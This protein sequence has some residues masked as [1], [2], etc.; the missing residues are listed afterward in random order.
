MKKVFLL[1]LI[2]V[3]FTIL[4]CS[5][6]SQKAVSKSAPTVVQAS[7]APAITSPAVE[8]AAALPVPSVGRMNQQAWHSENV[9]D[10]L[11]TA[12]ALRRTSL[13]GKFD[14]VI[15]QEG[16]NS[17]LS[18]VRHERWESVRHQPAKGK[19]MDLRVKFEDGQE[20]RIE[21]DELGFGTENL[22][23]VLWSYPAKADAPIGPV[24]EGPKSDSV[25]GDQLLIQDMMKHK[26]MLL[27]VAPGVTTQFDMTGLAHE[28]EKVRTPKA[29]PVLEASQIAE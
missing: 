1:M 6:N 17:F 25:G 14:L 21:W 12:V 27:E 15:L 23:S 16:A 5:G 19:I 29:Q 20:Q 26:T 28:I 3:L 10:R 13:D 18:F 7:A 4:G 8:P 2:G 9:S 24:L 22:Y 11:G